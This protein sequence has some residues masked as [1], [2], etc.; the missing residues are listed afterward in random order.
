M[1][2]PES[3]QLHVAMVHSSYPDDDL[4]PYKLKLASWDKATAENALIR[5]VEEDLTTNAPGC[6]LDTG[7]AEDAALSLAYAHGGFC[8]AHTLSV[9]VPKVWVASI[10]GPQEPGSSES[11]PAGKAPTTCSI[12]GCCKIQQTGRTKPFRSAKFCHEAKC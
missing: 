11:A 1:N 9:D 12:S 2:Q 5:Y 4:Q 10:T 6:Y 8:N 7:S 3:A